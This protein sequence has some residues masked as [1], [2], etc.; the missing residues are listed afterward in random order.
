MDY[1]SFKGQEY[2]GIYPYIDYE[3]GANS[4][5]YEFWMNSPKENK[6]VRLREWLNG[7]DPYSH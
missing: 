4:D 2:L 1:A 6:Y 7:K 5:R 3:K